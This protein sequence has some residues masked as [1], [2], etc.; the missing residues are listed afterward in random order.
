MVFI[1]AVN[2]INKKLVVLNW[3]VAAIMTAILLIYHYSDVAKQT[4]HLNATFISILLIC[5]MILIKVLKNEGNVSKKKK[6]IGIS[7][8]IHV[9]LQ[10]IIIILFNP[11]ITLEKSIITTITY[12]F[13]LIEIGLVVSNF[14]VATRKNKQIN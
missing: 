2:K 4:Y 1:T 13:W 9:I 8:A 5:Y 14:I 11:A 3:V 6:I 12:S 7:I 10:A